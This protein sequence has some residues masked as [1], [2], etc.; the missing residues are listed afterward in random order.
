MKII[1]SLKD[2]KLSLSFEVFPPKTDSA[3]ESVKTAVEEIAQP[4][5]Q[6]AEQAATR[7]TLQRT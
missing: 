6:A 4:T 5:V 3:F 2:D 7:L 1:D